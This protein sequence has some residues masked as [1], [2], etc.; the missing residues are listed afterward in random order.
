MGKLSLKDR[1]WGGLYSLGAGE[2]YS[3]TRLRLTH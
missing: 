2:E 1:G 3:R